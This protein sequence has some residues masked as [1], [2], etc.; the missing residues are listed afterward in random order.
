MNI[1]RSSRLLSHPVSCTLIS[2]KRCTFPVL[3]LPLRLQLPSTLVY[4][5]QSHQYSQPPLWTFPLSSD[6]NNSLAFPWG[7]CFTL[8]GVAVL[9]FL[10]LFFKK[11]ILF[12]YFGCAGSLL[13][14]GDHLVGG[15]WAGHADFLVVACMW[16]LVPWPGTEPGASALGAWSLNHCATREV[17]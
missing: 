15:M 6:T 4:H 3:F 11:Y 7:H 2:R 16:D 13:W 9:S 1:T 14:L 10:F 8:Q 17:L 12:I 5:Q